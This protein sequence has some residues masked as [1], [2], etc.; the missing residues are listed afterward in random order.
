MKKMTMQPKRF[1]QTAAQ[2]PVEC[3][4]EQ[5]ILRSVI[6]ASTGVAS[7]GWII[8]PGGI[9][10]ERFEKNP[11]ITDRHFKA[12][13]GQPSPEPVVIGSAI[14]LQHGQTELAGGVRFADTALGRDYA[15]LCGINP[16]RTPHMRG[17][18]VE[19]PV[20]ESQHVDWSAARKISAQYWDEALAERLQDRTAQV[21]VATRFELTN[22][23]ACALGA[24]R[25]ALTR[26]CSAG[27]AVAGELLARM[28]LEAAGDTLSIL[29]NEMAGQQARLDKLEEDILALR[30]DGAAAAARGDTADVLAELRAMRMRLTQEK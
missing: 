30:R 17:W 7:D 2:R 23:A 15:Y 18:S 5:R 28:D 19:G 13:P 12:A 26:A 16:D 21:H 14:D 9:N 29:R 6:F 24:D 1:I 11:I 8:L 27:V 25:S 10:L 20:L 4:V 3:D 22:V